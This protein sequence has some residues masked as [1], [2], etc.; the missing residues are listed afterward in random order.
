MAMTSTLQSVPAID[1]RSLRSAY[2]FVNSS[3]AAAASRVAGREL[4]Q[5]RSV[6]STPVVTIRCMASPPKT[7]RHRMMAN[8]RRD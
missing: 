2:C 5:A 1:A 4:L 7:V 8:R 3:A 6:M